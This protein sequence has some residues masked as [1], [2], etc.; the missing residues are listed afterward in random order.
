M[1]EDEKAEAAAPSLDP[2]TAEVLRF[3]DRAKGTI[4]RI[5]V[6]TASPSAANLALELRALRE[7]LSQTAP[8]FEATAQSLDSTARVLERVITMAGER[9]VA[10]RRGQDGAV[11]EL[12]VSVD[13]LVRQVGALGAWRAWWTRQVAT[14]AVVL[15]LVLGAGIALAWRAHALAQGTHDILQQI[16]QNQTKAQATKSGKRR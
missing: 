3:L 9:L 4:A 14:C 7:G 5:E 12:R 10:F 13:R 11:S 16:L 1:S 8:N 6:P 15:A 2:R